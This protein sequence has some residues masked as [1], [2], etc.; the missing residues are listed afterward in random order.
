MLSEKM[1]AALN[2][3]VN[4]ELY[5]AYIYLSMAGYFRKMNLPGFAHWME[6]QAQEEVGH[7]MKIYGFIDERGGAVALKA[8]DGPP[9]EWA[10]PLEAFQAAYGHEQKVTGMINDL[11]DL[12]D[13]VDDK[14]A[15]AFLQW[16]VTEQVEEEASADEVVQKLKL[17]GDQPGP[18]FMLDN[19]MGR[20]GS[21]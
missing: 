14:A 13:E 20:R 16:F 12:A 7:A 21:E 3:Q 18:L 6:V 9:T 5:S 17:V 10:S 15:R 8:V 11:V 2:E 19:V 1:E 4:A